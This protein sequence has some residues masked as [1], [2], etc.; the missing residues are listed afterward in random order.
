MGQF[1]ILVEFNYWDYLY[2]YTE[3]LVD[4]QNSSSF[5]DNWDLLAPLQLILLMNI[6]YDILTIIHQWSSPH[7]WLVKGWAHDGLALEWFARHISHNPRDNKNWLTGYRFTST[8][9]TIL[10]VIWRHHR[11]SCQSS[12]QSCRAECSP[13]GIGIPH[14]CEGSIHQIPACRHPCPN[15]Y[16]ITS[17]DCCDAI[18]PVHRQSS[19]WQGAGNTIQI[20]LGKHDHLGTCW[21]W[22]K[23]KD[24][25]N[26]LQEMLR[27]DVLMPEHES[28]DF[29]LY[30][31]A[32][33]FRCTDSRQS[34]SQP[35]CYLDLSTTSRQWP[36]SPLRS[37]QNHRSKRGPTKKNILKAQPKT[38][39]RQSNLA[40]AR[41][42]KKKSHSKGCKA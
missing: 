31:F 18:R 35:R 16:L 9:W 12:K 10:I 3:R 42:K 20:A 22:W 41:F 40:M 6:H 36:T 11:E 32:S 17:H 21:R 34:A 30:F 28:W 33:I 7:L 2:L 4:F 26:H 1:S 37:G 39:F 19:K 14:H 38:I 24:Y 13:G 15:M 23:Q 27:W 25:R 29:C 8:P 5:S